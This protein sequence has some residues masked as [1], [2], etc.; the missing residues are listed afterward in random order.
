MKPENRAGWDKEKRV[1]VVLAGGLSQRFGEDKIFAKI[2]EETF[3]EKMV[4]TLRRSQF[5]VF[6][7]LATPKKS[8]VTGVSFLL[9]PLPGEG[10][11]QALYG[12]LKK[13]PCEKLLLVPCDMPFLEDSVLQALWETGKKADI[14]LLKN[15]GSFFPLPGVYSKN[16]LP[17]IEAK[18]KEGKRDLK[19]LLETKLTLATLSVKGKTLLNINT[20][21]DLLSV[22]ERL[23]RMNAAL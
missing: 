5:E 20:K 13:L 9:D 21:E 19:S 1:A 14:A 23:S 15:N 16:T 11:L 7:S 10:P 2:G 12:V 22:V 6:L 4:R 18:L 17:Y 8:P 3:L